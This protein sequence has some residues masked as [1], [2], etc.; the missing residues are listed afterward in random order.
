MCHYSKSTRGHA[1]LVAST[2]RTAIGGVATA[3]IA[4]DKPNP[5]PNSTL[6]ERRRSFYFDSSRDTRTTTPA[7]RISRRAYPSPS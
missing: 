2:C 3:F 6:T 5:Q 4:V 7:N 1:E